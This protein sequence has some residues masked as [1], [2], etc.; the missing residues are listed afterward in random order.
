MP[1]T[2]GSDDLYLLIHSLSKEEKGYFR[3]FATRHSTSGSINLSLFNAISKQKEFEEAELKKNFKN[4]ART[5]VYLKEMIMDALLIYYRNNHPHIQLLNQ[6]QKIHLLLIKGL[7]NEALRLLKKAL[8]SSQAMELFSISIYLERVQRDLIAQTF[9]QKSDLLK[10]IADYTSALQKHYNLEQNLTQLELLSMQWHEKS[11]GI[12]NIA[13]S[14]LVEIKSKLTVQKADSKRAN[15]KLI[16][17]ENWLAR[18]SDND[19]N[20]LAVTEKR[21]LHVNA[22]R[23]KH[24]PSFNAFSA[25]DNHILSCIDAK[26]FDK[27]IHYSNEM[28][29][30]VDKMSLNY[31]ISF[32]WGNLRKWMT[33]LIAEKYETGLKSMNQNNE[34]VLNLLSTTQ[35]APGLR[36]VRAYYIL[37]AMLF[38]CNKKYLE[39]WLCL[40]DSFH[41]L[42]Q[43]QTNTPDMLILQLMTQL[44]MENYSLLKNMTSQANK[45]IK[46]QSSSKN[47][48]SILLHFFMK[49]TPENK[50]SLKKQ[51]WLELEKANAQK[52]NLFDLIPFKKWLLDN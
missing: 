28:I 20:L 27:A 12:K 47:S 50:I 43:N 16:E 52:E 46:L 2:I 3:K 41:L 11:L 42:K 8:N 17:L 31:N 45:K 38:F 32:V 23:K 36:A 26:E 40:N 19:R 14:A 15:I 1:R 30:S 49:V 37:R 22:F 21:L 4:Y 44:E 51:T 18:F 9:N 10:L 6:I 35:E 25:F 7:Y 29:A 5:K 13:T 24:D 48:H 33:Y 34:A 39:C